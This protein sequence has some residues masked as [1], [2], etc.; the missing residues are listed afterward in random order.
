[1]Y[2]SAADADADA[3]AAPAASWFYRSSS[4]FGISTASSRCCIPAGP[5]L[6]LLAAS[7][8]CRAIQLVKDHR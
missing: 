5:R 8:T 2:D 4:P 3:D 7:T 1:M 6:G